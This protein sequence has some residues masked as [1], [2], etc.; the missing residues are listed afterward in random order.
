MGIVGR[1]K[2]RP[3]L[4]A[5][6]LALFA[7]LAG[8]CGREYGFER[9]AVP[10]PKEKS[11]GD[12]A[13]ADIPALEARFEALWP[14]RDDPQALRDAIA[15]LR[16]ILEARGGEHYQT[17]VLLARSHYLLGEVTEDPDRKLEAYEAGMRYGD[18]ALHTIAA[19]REAFEKTRSLEDAVESVPR[20]GI[21]AIYWDAVNQG[22]W[23]NAKGK[24]KVLFMKDKVKRM[25][26]RVLALDE[27]WWF[28]AAHR[29]LGA[30]F[31]ALPTFAG[32]DL[33]ASKA[34]FEKSLAIAP[35]FFATRVLLAEYWARNANDRRTY[36]AELERVISSPADSIPEVAP[37]QRIEQKKARKLLAEIDDYFDEEEKA[38][39]APPPA[40]PP[41]A[42]AGS[43]P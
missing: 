26:E 40:P 30:Y 19:F 21:E 23:A 1:M 38:G 33:A 25:I 28:G 3:V 15:L 2:A 9:E 27:V 13:R 39:A 14:R 16:Q 42:S 32:R 43:R 6:L 29:Y 22:K 41:A 31:S 5:L 36:R 34:H 11:G 37:E 18:L 24:V 8:S 4:G 12:G 35:D 17:F 10:P 20:S 7:P